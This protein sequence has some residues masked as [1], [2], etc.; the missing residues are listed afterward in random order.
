[1]SSG[2]VSIG[3]SDGRGGDGVSGGANDGDDWW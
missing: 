1:M 3:V 2:G